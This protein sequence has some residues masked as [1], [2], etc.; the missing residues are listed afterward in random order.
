MHC[1]PICLII[2]P[3][4]IVSY[5]Y[6]CFCLWNGICIKI[7]LFLNGAW[8]YDSKYDWTQSLSVDPLGNICYDDSVLLC[9]WTII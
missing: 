3:F 2:F 1:Y 4:V 6:A 9:V 5:L 8:C 7:V